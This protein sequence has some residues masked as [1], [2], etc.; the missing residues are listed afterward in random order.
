M[1][2]WIYS[3]ATTFPSITAASE[4]QNSYGCWRVSRVVSNINHSWSC[5]ISRIGLATGGKQDQTFWFSSCTKLSLYYG[6]KAPSFVKLWTFF[7][8]QNHQSCDSKFTEVL[9]WERTQ[10]Y[11]S[12]TLWWLLHEDSEIR[13]IG[14]QESHCPDKCWGWSCRNYEFVC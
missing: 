14:E 4:H 2:L 9:L 12:D 6:S 11:V 8:R 7:H 3:L 1:L 5:L 10:N 13:L